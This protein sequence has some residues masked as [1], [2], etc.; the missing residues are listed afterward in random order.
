MKNTSMP[1]QSNH[2][3]IARQWKMLQQVPAHGH[4]L[5]AAEICE[6]LAAL[7]RISYTPCA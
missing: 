4:G 6:K 5:T 2:K 3:T 1:K 7:A